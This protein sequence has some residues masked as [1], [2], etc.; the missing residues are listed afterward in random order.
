[1]VRLTYFESGL[2]VVMG[3]MASGLFK[4]WKTKMLLDILRTY[5]V[6]A[7]TL[8]LKYMDDFELTQGNCIA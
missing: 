6:T 1:M 5:A 4:L 3:R 7:V 8:Y 2:C